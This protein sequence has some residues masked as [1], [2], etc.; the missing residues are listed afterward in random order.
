MGISRASSLSKIL[1]RSC[2]ASARGQQHEQVSRSGSFDY[3]ARAIG[4]GVHNSFGQLGIPEATTTI[5]HA[6]CMLL[7][8]S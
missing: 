5:R 6:R 7:I 1:Q 2:P 8:S 3:I 4:S